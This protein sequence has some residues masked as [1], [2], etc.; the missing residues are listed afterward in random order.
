MPCPPNNALGRA[1]LR[2]LHGPPPARVPMA[3]VALPLYTNGGLVPP[4]VIP[5]QWDLS[6]PHSMLAFGEL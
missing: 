6:G 2:S 3:G 1:W 5:T 4:F